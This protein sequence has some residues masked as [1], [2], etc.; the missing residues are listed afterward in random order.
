MDSSRQGL[1][2]ARRVVVKV[3]TAV[4]AREDGGMAL[5]RLGALVEQ[6]HG[7][8]ADGR[9]VILVSSGAV[10]L[11]VQRLGLDRKPT[12]RVDRQACAA[13]GQGA[14]LGLYE[15]LFAKLGHR[16]AQVLLTE[17][18]FGDRRRHV[19]LAATLERLLELGAVPVI[20][21]N[22]VVSDSLG[23]SGRVFED[24]DRLAAL[25]AAGVGCDAVV[26]LTD[27]D[28]VFTAPPGT[29]GAERISVLADQAVVVGAGSAVGRGGIQAK[30]DA[31]RVAARSGCA[32]V[33]ASGVRPDVL[34]AVFAGDDVGTLVPAEAGMAR[35]RQWIAYAAVPEGVLT[36][37]AG[38]R[39][40]LVE[41]Q[42]S[43]LAPG[44][45]A[46]EGEFEAGAVVSVA[47]A[48]EEF[49]RG[50]CAASASEVR[51]R[52]GQSGKTKALVHRDH[53]VMLVEER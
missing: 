1:R 39:K 2:D 47:C 46:V 12:S 11:G 24:N 35:R 37:D 49:A 27:V 3:G 42:A 30:I 13:A 16:V 20:N 21:E 41:R 32:A 33:I 8:I 18:D 52:M 9:E 6:I 43:L 44:V 28:G 19:N 34:G 26:L 22:D 23:P 53:V 50:I 5:G 29:P 31:A 36:V 38:A 14:L 15:H 25:V 51:Q 10:G 7:L 40:A 17:H 48:G 45:V 4:V